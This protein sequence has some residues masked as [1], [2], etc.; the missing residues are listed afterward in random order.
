MPP[1]S[2]FYHSYNIVALFSWVSQHSDTKRLYV[3]PKFSVN[4]LLL[5][6]LL[7]D[8]C[9]I[10]GITFNGIFCQKINYVISW[11]V[12]GTPISEDCTEIVTRSLHSNHAQVSSL[13]VRMHGFHLCICS[14]TS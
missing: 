6:I 7:I 8:F 1:R 9:L 10:F 11:I 5:D 13:E 2:I 4:G 12:E 14:K 3:A